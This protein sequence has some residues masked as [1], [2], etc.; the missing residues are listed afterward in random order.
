MRKELRHGEAVQEET[1][2]GSGE[3]SWMNGASEPGTQAEAEGKGGNVEVE[4]RGVGSGGGVDG[5]GFGQK[6]GNAAG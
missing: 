5:T 2:R 3:V 6:V 1:G 4:D